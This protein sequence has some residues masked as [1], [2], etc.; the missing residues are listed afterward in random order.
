[1]RSTL[2]MAK[3]MIP[4]PFAYNTDG[5]VWTQ[6]AEEFGALNVVCHASCATAAKQIATALNL[7]ERKELKQGKSR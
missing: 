1:M 6:S 3:G 5:L 2:A 7:L 4:G